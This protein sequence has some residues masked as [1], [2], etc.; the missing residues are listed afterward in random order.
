MACRILVPQSGTEPGALA[1]NEWNSN[2]W[3]AREFLYFFKK[4]IQI[5]KRSLPSE[6][7]L[8]FPSQAQPLSP[9]SCVFFQRRAR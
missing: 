6:I 7:P 3:P 2:H 9:G 5:S 1:V 8:R 4:K